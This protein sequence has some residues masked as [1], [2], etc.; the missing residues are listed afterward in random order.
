MTAEQR[1]GERE[2]I[3]ACRRAMD[4][5]ADFRVL[6]E[7]ARDVCELANTAL[8]ALDAAEARERELLGVV[9]DIHEVRCE[10]WST[11]TGVSPSHHQEPY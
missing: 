11:A 6:R 4:L 2:K 9:H 5:Q 3:I 8:S 1:V 7:A 10:A